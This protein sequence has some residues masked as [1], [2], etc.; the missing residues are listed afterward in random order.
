MEL[1]KESPVV[2]EKINQEATSKDYK[3]HKN[4]IKVDN[5]T[6]LEKMIADAKICN[7]RLKTNKK[8][9]EAPEPSTSRGLSRTQ[10]RGWRNDKLTEKEIGDIKYFLGKGWDIRSTA[11]FCGVSYSTVQKIKAS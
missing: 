11:V 10:G 2:I 4:I 7:S 1:K 3:Q 6:E 5:M 8:T 9:I